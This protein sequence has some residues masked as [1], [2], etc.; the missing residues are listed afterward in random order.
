M[1]ALNAHLKMS[2]GRPWESD[3]SEVSQGA[4]ERGGRELLAD[5]HPRGRRS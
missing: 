4:R 3:L 2:L 1:R 5:E